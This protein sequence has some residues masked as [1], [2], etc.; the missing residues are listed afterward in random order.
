M[1]SGLVGYV[2]I[3]VS[4]SSTLLLLYM[5]SYIRFLSGISL[6]VVCFVFFFPVD[7]FGLYLS[8]AVG[9]LSTV[10][11]VGSSVWRSDACE[12]RF[13]AGVYVALGAVLCGQKLL[14]GLLFCFLLICE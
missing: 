7:V 9:F 8:A 10:F 1:F 12:C 5:L 13:Q 3:V 14:V 4:V 11:L 6:G 2:F